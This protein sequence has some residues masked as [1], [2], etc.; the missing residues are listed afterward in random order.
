MKKAAIIIDDYK[1]PA[2]ER[3]LGDAGIPFEES[4]GITVNTLTL[5]IKGKSM[6]QLLE[7]KPI[8]ATANEE[9]RK[10]KS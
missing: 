6:K 2:F 10:L 8:I 9:G 1:L 3:I 4:A 7:W 5:T